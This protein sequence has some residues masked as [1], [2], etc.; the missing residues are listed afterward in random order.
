MFTPTV[1]VVV[2]VFQENVKILAFARDVMV[3]VKDDVASNMAFN[4]NVLLTK[5]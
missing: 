5:K 2:I 4:G 3:I 1:K